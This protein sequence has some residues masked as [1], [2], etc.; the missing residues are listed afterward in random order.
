MRKRYVIVLLFILGG[1]L[2]AACQSPAV[3]P[4]ATP[5]PTATAT[6]NPQPWQ[7]LTEFPPLP[8]ETLVG[9]H[10]AKF[11]I[12]IGDD[13]QV[14]YSEDGGANWQPSEISSLALYGLDIV[15]RDTAWVCGNRSTRLTTDGARTWQN[16][17]DFGE[18]I[19]NNCRFL[20]FLDS[21]TGWAATS[22]KLGSTT[23]GASTWTDLALP[24]DAGKIAAI[25]LYAAGKGY[26]LDN[27][28]NLFSTED[29]GQTWNPAGPLP[30]GDLTIATMN[31][32]VAAMRFQNAIRGVVIIP[33]VVG[34]TGQVAAFQTY[35]GGK[36]WKRQ[37]V[38]DSFCFPVLSHDGRI[39]TLYSLPMNV[40]VMQYTGI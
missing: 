9:F 24:K 29:N 36:T 16:A 20:S 13:S 15:D 23:D 26:L 22:S 12:Y 17:A 21:K 8:L 27:S 18:G 28:G 31:P 3:A 2:L 33:A 19:P 32:P 11:G 1:I 4:T 10:D 35:D 14:F 38:T 34:G 6:E 37:P 25:S 39:L 40:L 5:E 30:L 7:T